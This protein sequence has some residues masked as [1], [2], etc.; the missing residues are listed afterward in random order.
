LF[1]ISVIGYGIGYFDHSLLGLP[2]ECVGI[3]IF[4]GI[5]T[6]LLIASCILLPYLIGITVKDL[7]SNKP[8]G[9]TD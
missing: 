1:G 8:G 7:V 6:L 4:T 3:D 2:Q 9:Y 5:I